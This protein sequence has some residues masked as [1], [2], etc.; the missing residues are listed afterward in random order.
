[1]SDSDLRELCLSY[2]IIFNTQE[3]DGCCPA[4]DFEIRLLFFINMQTHRQSFLS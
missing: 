3:K 4:Q 1:M 2:Y